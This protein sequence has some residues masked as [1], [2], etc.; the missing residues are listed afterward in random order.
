[1]PLLFCSRADQLMRFIFVYS[2]V[3]LLKCFHQVRISFMRSLILF[4]YTAESDLTLN[5][6]KTTQ[7]Q[8]LQVSHSRLSE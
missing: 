7:S 2:N 5:T 6:K 8:N 3:I 1:M 4:T